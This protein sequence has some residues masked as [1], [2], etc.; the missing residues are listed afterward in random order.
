MSSSTLDANGQETI[1]VT[2]NA[3]LVFHGTSSK[4]SPL[5][6]RYFY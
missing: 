2:Y 5:S 1:V 4:M 3:S 6:I